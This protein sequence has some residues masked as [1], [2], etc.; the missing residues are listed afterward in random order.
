MGRAAVEL[1]KTSDDAFDAVITAL[2]ARAAAIGVVEAIPAAE[3]SAAVREGWIAV[4]RRGSRE[5][6]AVAVTPLS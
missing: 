1:C 2:V 4:P 3:Q 5:Q 6:L